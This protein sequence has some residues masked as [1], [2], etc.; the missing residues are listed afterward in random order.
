M[1]AG[2][3]EEGG[4]VEHVKR[5]GERRNGRLRAVE[6]EGGYSLLGLGAQCHLLIL[7]WS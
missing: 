4:R 3:G 1:F 2:E 6:M 5:K 7:R